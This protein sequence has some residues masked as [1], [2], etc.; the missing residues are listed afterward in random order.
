MNGYLLAKVVQVQSQEGGDT[1]QDARVG[2]ASSTSIAAAELLPAHDQPLS[3]PTPPETAHK[4]PEPEDTTGQARR[5]GTT[6]SST[7]MGPQ[8]LC[9]VLSVSAPGITVTTRSTASMSTTSA[10]TLTIS[11]PA[12]TSNLPS[13]LAPITSSSHLMVNGFFM[14]IFK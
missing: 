7:H 10:T 14:A 1:Y 2:A 5:R 12:L 9:R 6:S 11:S 13:T 4:F 8:V 3:P